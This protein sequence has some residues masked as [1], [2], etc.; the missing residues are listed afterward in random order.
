MSY[1]GKVITVDMTQVAVDGP[2]VVT[3]RTSAGNDVKI[4]VPSFGILL[5]KAHASIL[6]A[7][8]LKV[9]DAVEV[10]GTVGEDGTIVPCQSEDHYLRVMKK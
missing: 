1:S 7:S 6:G 4:N 2:A 5:C 8:T 9:G 3:L 10:R